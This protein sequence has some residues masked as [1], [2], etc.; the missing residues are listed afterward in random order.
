M[1]ADIIEL[2]NRSTDQNP[3]NILNRAMAANLKNII[4]IGESPDGSVYFNISASDIPL[5]NWLLDCAKKALL[6]NSFPEVEE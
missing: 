5:N 6:D 2:G 3:E 4:V 1:T